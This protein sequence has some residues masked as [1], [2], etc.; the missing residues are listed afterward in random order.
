MYSP[1]ILAIVGLAVLLTG[2]GVWSL[3]W[4]RL[5]IVAAVLCVPVL[6]LPAACSVVALRDWVALAVPPGIV[7]AIV[8]VAVGSFRVR[9]SGDAKLVAWAVV[10]LAV[11]L[12]FVMRCKT[13]IG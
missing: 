8:T 3:R 9:F 11:V 1:F 10:G 13:A 2:A 12:T 7:A 4:A 5:Q 6:L